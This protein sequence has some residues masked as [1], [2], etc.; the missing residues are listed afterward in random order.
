MPQVLNHFEVYLISLS[1]KWNAAENITLEVTT[2]GFFLNN[3]YS[4]F[5]FES[6]DR[7][8]QTVSACNNDFHML[9]MKEYD[10]SVLW[11]Q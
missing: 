8:F 11:Y 7:L 4:L 10:L 3:L 9:G 1:A 6:P 2:S 5:K